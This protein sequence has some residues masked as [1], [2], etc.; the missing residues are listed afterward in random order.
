MIAIYTGDVFTTLDGFGSY[1][2]HGDWGGYWANKVPSSWIAA[3]RSTARNCGWYSERTRS[4]CSSGS[5]E[6]S[7]GIQRRSTP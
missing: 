3:S 6:R 7:R 1:K 4:G 5:S 2:A